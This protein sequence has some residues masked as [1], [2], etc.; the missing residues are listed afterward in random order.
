M[1]IR[2]KNLLKTKE[3]I[4]LNDVQLDFIFIYKTK[5]YCC[6]WLNK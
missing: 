3:H 6:R 4:Y 2:N 1:S 5:V